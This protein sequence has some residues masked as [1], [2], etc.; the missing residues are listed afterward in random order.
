MAKPTAEQNGIKKYDTYHGE[1]LFTWR[2]L[3]ETMF[4]KRQTR[5]GNLEVRRA[6]TRSRVLDFG[7]FGPKDPLANSQHSLVKEWRCAGRGPRNLH[8][9]RQLGV[10]DLPGIISPEECRCFGNL[11]EQFQH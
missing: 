6:C 7:R 8:M 5:A 1:C 11:V 2:G 10:I 4:R 9:K 3:S